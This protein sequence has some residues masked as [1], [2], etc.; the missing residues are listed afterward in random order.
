MTQVETEMVTVVFND[1]TG[2]TIKVISLECPKGA[3]RIGAEMAARYLEQKFHEALQDALDSLN[4][5]VANRR[6]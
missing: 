2:A 5:T 1:P 3:G 6:Q 4:L